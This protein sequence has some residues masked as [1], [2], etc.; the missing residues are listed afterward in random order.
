MPIHSGTPIAI[1]LHSSSKTREINS[2]DEIVGTLLDAPRYADVK[3]P[4][5]S[6]SCGERWGGGSPRFP[7]LLNCYH[8]GFRV[9]C[10]DDIVR[11]AHLEVV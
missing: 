2:C 3:L 7:R 6:V 10:G 9:T 8:A 4:Q 5:D 11:S 1:F